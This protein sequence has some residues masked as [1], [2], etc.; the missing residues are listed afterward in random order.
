[1]NIYSSYYCA[2]PQAGI[3]S[4]CLPNSKSQAIRHT[5]LL[6]KKILTAINI[7]IIL[8]CL[9]R[10]EENSLCVRNK[11]CITGSFVNP[12]QN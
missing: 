8:Y 1:M 5:Y 7:W 10:A 6:G 2:I 12:K 11:N 3:R 4:G 9:H